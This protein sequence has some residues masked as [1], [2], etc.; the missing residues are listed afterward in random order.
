MPS[1]V[2]NLEEVVPGISDTIFKMPDGTELVVPGDL[3]TE[4]TFELLALFGDLVQFQENAAEKVAAE[5]SSSDVVA[6]V[7]SDLKK[8]TDLIDAKLLAIFQ[9]R[10]P[11]LKVLPFG[12]KS[13]N[14]V[15]GAIFEMVGI[16]SPT[17]PAGPLKPPPP[18]KPRKPRGGTS[19][20]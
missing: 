11:D 3:P 4:T 19:R 10:Q 18:T 1:N 7:R 8:V 12:S 2:I 6:E 13:T 14:Y 20:R 9:I 15:L 5:S 16:A 17:Q